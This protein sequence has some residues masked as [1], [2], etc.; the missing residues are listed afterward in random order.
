M[1]NK[2]QCMSYRILLLII[3]VARLSSI[4]GQSW[5]NQKLNKEPLYSDVSLTQDYDGDGDLDIIVSQ[6]E[7]NQLV[8][9]ENE[10]TRQWP[11]HLITNQDFGFRIADVDTADFDNDGLVDYL[12][13]MTG[14]DD[15]ELAWYQR[16]PDG[17]YIKWTIDTNKDFIMADVADLNGDGYMDIG[18][19]GLGNSDEEGRIY[20]NQQNLFFIFSKLP[21]SVEGN[22]Y[23]DAINFGDWDGDGDKDVVVA[24]GGFINTI[25]GEGSGTALL[26]NN[27]QGLFTIF[28]YIQCDYSRFTSYANNIELVDLNGDNL[29]D[30]LG[31][32][33]AAF[34]GLVFTDHNEKVEYNSFD[35][36]IID[37]DNDN[38]DTGGDFLIFDVD[39][40]GY[41]DIIRQHGGEKRIT[42]LYQNS[43]LSFRREVIDYF[44]DNAG[45]PTA[46]MSY[47]DLDGDGDLDLVIPEKGNID[48]D[49]SWYE[50]IDGK[51]VKHYTYSQM[52]G[53]QKCKSGDI[54]KDGDID[55]VASVGNSIVEENEIV[56][57]ENLGDNNFQS[58]RL[59]DS[60]NFPT[61]IELADI[62]GDG[63]LDLF[64][65]T[66]EGTDLIWLDNN[67]TLYDWPLS[68]IDINVNQSFG[69]NA[70]DLDKDNDTDV[71]IASNNDDKIFWYKNDGTGKFQK[72]VLDGNVDAP[73]DIE[74]NDWDNDGDIDIAV[75]CASST[76]TIVT[77]TN[78]GSQVYTR[79]IE[80]TGELGSDI[81][82]GDWDGDN[83]QDIVFSIFNSSPSNP[84]FSVA[85]LKN[86]SMGF[87]KDTILINTEDAR[88]IK[89]SDMNEDGRV[90]IIIGKNN[91]SR[92]ELWLMDSIQYLKRIE[93]SKISGSTDV[94]GIDVAD[95]DNNGLKDIV[96]TDAASPKGEIVLISF[97]CYQGPK[98]SK[99]ITNTTC[100]LVNGK[101]EITPLEGSKHTYL[102]SNGSKDQIIDSLALGTYKV[103]VTDD[104]GCTSTAEIKIE[105]TP[106]I[107]IN[108]TK[109]NETC[110][111]A[112]G[113]ATVKSTNN[114]A[115]ANYL[116]SNG[117][118]T[119]TATN[120]AA[121]SYTV[122]VTDINGCTKTS[123]I[124]IVSSPV[125]N[126]TLNP[127][128]TSCNKD[129]GK[130][131]LLTSGGANIKSYLWSNGA[132][133]KSIANLSG[134]TYIV[135]VTDVND[136]EIIDTVE[137]IGKVNPIVNLGP[138]IN[139]TQ[140]TEATLDA[141]AGN[142]LSY[143]WSTG[144]TTQTIIVNALGTYSVTVTNAQ[145]CSASDEIVIKLTTSN[146]EIEL[147]KMVNLYPNPTSSIINIGLDYKINE[148][149][150]FNILNQKI[151]ININDT[152]AIDLSE[153]EC[154][155][156]FIK[157]SLEN[158]IT[159]TKSLIKI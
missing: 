79:K 53:I 88:T 128:P 17:T 75:V 143:K 45:N 74:A 50:N 46:K 129:D 63:D 76:N 147:S 138:D 77:Y 21:D 93:I 154:G 67:G 70:V 34:G 142:D 44:W 28:K 103:T 15:G 131:T 122:M 98:L 158:D 156:Y 112:N 48:G 29:M 11:K 132:T 60:I 62:D 38:I 61:D 148:I 57:Y 84:R 69:I 10:P 96:F 102:W 89:L 116:W 43:N 52:R 134:G 125:T 92:V 100:G 66:K 39:R 104:G 145:G 7:P 81:E 72:N 85:Y 54:D 5:Q 114:I 118:T 97:L 106:P 130:V 83:I 12:V 146:N 42:V 136:C 58:W 111:K 133:T 4:N 16:R 40:N 59:N 153:L 135:T 65:A 13:C 68:Y 120:L 23:S 35:G 27:G 151:K 144:E 113:T 24:G 2:I 32:S 41:L 18:A 91:E 20:L 159:V 110:N 117:A 87:I 155:I 150:I 124:V 8:W 25:T 6:R 55:I 152:N 78:N 73:I 119:E 33:S 36:K 26:L 94:L 80:F 90:D 19:V 126:V 51:L 47:G 71:I 105:N 49:V 99:T 107:A 141:G 82:I 14:V 3:C 31:F 108:I 121:G 30:I 157:F 22:T 56:V 101:A 149:D 37:D 1:I 115:I 95:F 109:T 86:K 139:I 127:T 9:L 137:V 123:T 140:G 64:V